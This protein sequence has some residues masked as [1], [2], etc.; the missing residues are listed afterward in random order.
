[1]VPGGLG[2][3]EAGES[4][5]DQSRGAGGPGLNMSHPGSRSISTTALHGKIW[6]IPHVMTNVSSLEKT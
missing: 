2:R 3:P 4:K 6:F 5:T 1:M